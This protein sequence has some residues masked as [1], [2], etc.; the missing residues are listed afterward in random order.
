MKILYSIVIMILSSEGCND[1]GHIKN[2]DHQQIDNPKADLN[3]VCEYK[4]EFKKVYFIDC[5]R[6]GY[7]DSPDIR[8]ILN[9]DR[10][11]MGD[12]PLWFNGYRLTDSLAL[13]TQ[14]EIQA[15]SIERDTVPRFPDDRGNKR[16]FL[17]CLMKYESEWL[18]SIASRFCHDQ[19]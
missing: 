13:L 3:A 8:K 2:K 9:Q 19:Q 1:H 4:D 15:D 6:R 10:S 17:F 14:K 18:D 7:N 16:V 12:F 11:R 5:I